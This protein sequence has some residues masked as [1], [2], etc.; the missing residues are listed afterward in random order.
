MRKVT[1]NIIKS[2]LTSFITLFMVVD[3][4]CLYNNNS[5]K[6]INKNFVFQYISYKQD[7]CRSQ[8]E[9]LNSLSVIKLY[10]LTVK[11]E[12]IQQAKLFIERFQIP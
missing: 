8:D 4:I 7:A 2:F 9:D 10:G 6:K 1:S 3:F 11:T 12:Y 5:N